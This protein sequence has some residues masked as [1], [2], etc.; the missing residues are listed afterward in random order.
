VAN[1]SSADPDNVRAAWAKLRTLSLNAAPLP[2]RFSAPVSNS[3]ESAPSEFAPSGPSAET[4]VSRLA[5]S[6]SSSTGV[7]VRVLGMTAPS[8][9]SGPDLARSVSCT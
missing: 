1:R 5:Y 3:S 8:A 9:S 6:S 4:S 7:A 2:R